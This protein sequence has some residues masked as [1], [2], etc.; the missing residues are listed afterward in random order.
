MSVV[1]L[2][3][4]GQ[5][6]PTTHGGPSTSPPLFRHQNEAT[7]QASCTSCRPI[8]FGRCFQTGSQL[9]NLNA[10]FNAKLDA[11]GEELERIL[12]ILSFVEWVS[13]SD[14][15][16]LQQPEPI[17]GDPLEINAEPFPELL[18]DAGIRG[19]STYTALFHNFDMQTFTCKIC[20]RV[21][22]GEL[23]DAITHQRAGHFGHYPYRCPQ[24][25]CMLRFANEATMVGHQNATGH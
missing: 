16:R 5:G 11:M 12:F 14:F 6:T 4:P 23:E 13:Q 10:L 7:R 20:R 8:C 15:L 17:V 2:M 19:Q 22:S 3:T 24:T 1:G 21:V 9:V 25:Q 18:Q